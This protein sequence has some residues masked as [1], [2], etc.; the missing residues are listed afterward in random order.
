MNP[1]LPEPIRR[2][3]ITGSRQWTNPHPIHCHLNQE[4]ATANFL[5]IIHGGAKGADQIADRWARTQ[6]ENGA[7]VYIEVHK[8]N[9]ARYGST[10]GPQ[11]NNEM[12]KRGADKCYAY[13]IG[14]SRGTR[15][16]ILAATRAGIQTIITEGKADNTEPKVC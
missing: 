3:L 16:C 15:H 11:R 9:W 10:A 12:V 8:A 5:I 14:E 1:Y 13:P 7:R 2:I 6:H 4:L